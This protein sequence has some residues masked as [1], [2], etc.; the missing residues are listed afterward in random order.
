MDKKE[1]EFLKRIQ[2]TF[3]IEAKEHIR[4]FSARLIELENTQTEEKLAEIVEAMFRE[5]HSLKGASRSVDQRDAESVC[6]PLEK[7]LSAL[8][9]K[10]ISLSPILLGLFFNTVDWF[11]KFIAS[12]QN[13]QTSTDRQTLRE[14]IQRLKE[15]TSGQLNENLEKVKNVK[16]IKPVESVKYFSKVTNLPLSASQVSNESVRISISKLDPLLLQAEEMIQTKIAINHRSIEL[17]EIH[18]EII[19]WRNESSK[20][21]VGR[22]GASPELWNEW[23]EGNDLH[24]KK[25]EYRM[26]EIN[27]HTQRD[28]YRL[29]RMVDNHL[30]AM[31]QILMLPVSSLVEIFPAMVREIA[32]DQKKELEII[33]R[34]TELEIDKRILEELKDPLIHLIRNSIDHGIDTPQE[35]VKQNKPA[36]GTIILDFAAIEN[37]QFE[38][39]LSDDG[40]G[41]DR[42]HLLKTAIKSGILS[43]DAA[44]KL[45]P[46][47]V[48]NLIYQSGVS[49]SPIIS[50]ISGHGL[51]LSI[52]HEKV[53]KLNGK[54]S[55]ES[56]ADTGTS[57]RILL[58]ITLAVFRGIIVKVKESVFIVPTMNVDRVMKV[59]PGRIKTVENHETILID[60]KIIPVADLAEVLGL[61]EQKHKGSGKIGTGS[62][63][64]DQI[65]IVVLFSE[66][67]HIAF[68]VDD[69]AGEQQVLVKGMGKLLR[70]IRNISGATILGSGKVVPVLNITDLIKTAVQETA[71]IKEKSDNEK[72]IIKAGKILVVEDSITA[73]TMLKNILE[74]AGYNVITA[75]NGSDGFT[76]AGSGE[77][78]L[79]LSDVDMPEL[80]GFGLT[81][82]IRA[83]DKLKELPVMLLSALESREDREHGIGVGADAYI[84]KSSFDQGNLLE[85]IRK[86]I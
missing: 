84:V 56:E 50:Y 40:K 82:K 6:Q 12:D 57:F 59:E 77:F 35:R 75:V 61:H 4:A 30:D 41:I 43:E 33:I 60:D 58:P 86:L 68:K 3:R 67:N 25:L 22:S 19:E 13:S 65:Y 64:S 42:E 70:R 85:V 74:N 71:R 10:E 62:P 49:T 23:L 78:D 81:A 37:G 54:I 27:V 80:D 66:E 18:N 14:L 72:P 48:L 53:V 24:L 63:V 11:S 21:G 76:K 44:K 28:Q 31:K 79:I 5:I 51:G 45:L 36:R 17:K 55:V 69:I 46:E 9:H 39:T 29:N 73:R 2:A 32:R 7:A 34:G 20:W 15:I 52:V 26:A 8:K 83:D 16:D 1:E 38:I 47:E